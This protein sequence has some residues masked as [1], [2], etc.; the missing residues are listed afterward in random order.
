MHGK[1]LTNADAWAIA[2][3]QIGETIDF[4]RQKAIWTEGI[5]SVPIKMATVQ[6]INRDDNGVARV[7]L[8]AA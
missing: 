6:S 8:S 4:A 2:K 7:D 1:I 5:R 3:W